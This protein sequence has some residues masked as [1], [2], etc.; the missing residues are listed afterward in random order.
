MRGRDGISMGISQYFMPYLYPAKEMR[1][2]MLILSIA[3]FSEKPP[4]TNLRASALPQF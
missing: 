1:G 3:I 2:M 4:P